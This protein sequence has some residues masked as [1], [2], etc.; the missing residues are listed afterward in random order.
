MPIIKS[1]K[2]KM[3][4]DIVKTKRNNI[5]RNRLTSRMK[6]LTKAVKEHQL[7]ELP[8]LLTEAYKI[9]DTACK[10]NLIKK[11]NAARKKSRMARIVNEELTKN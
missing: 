8:K 11:N 10:K 3:K 9:I 6:E 2:K 5:V 1:A 4:Q 7:T